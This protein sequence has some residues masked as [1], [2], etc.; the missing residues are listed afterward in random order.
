MACSLGSQGSKK[1]MRMHKVALPYIQQ[2]QDTFTTHAP[3]SARAEKRIAATVAAG[4]AARPP[5]GRIAKSSVC[6]EGPDT[7]EYAISAKRSFP[8]QDA[9]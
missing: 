4:L 8:A 5:S 7:Q 2:C 1:K 9:A 3:G 6:S